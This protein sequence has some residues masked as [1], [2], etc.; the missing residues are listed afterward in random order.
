MGY[1]IPQKPE[2]AKMKVSE[3]MNRLRE[4]GYS[5]TLKGDKL[6]LHYERDG[7]PG[8]EVDPLFEELRAHKKEAVTFLREVQEKLEPLPLETP[9]QP[10]QAPV[11]D[12]VMN[13]EMALEAEGETQ[14]SLSFIPEEEKVLTIQELQTPRQPHGR[15]KAKMPPVKIYSRLFNEEIY[16]VADRE[17]MEALASN[18][19]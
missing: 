12:P 1:A 19:G 9:G 16:I 6:R 14:G 13:D 2:G 15:S 4:E 18:G 11:V 10:S 8:P 3:A 5:I 17:E 7:E